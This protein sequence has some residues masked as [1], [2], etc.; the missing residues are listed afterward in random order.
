MKIDKVLGITVGVIVFLFVFLFCYYGHIFHFPMPSRVY[1]KAVPDLFEKPEEVTKLFDNAKLRG[2]MEGATAGLGSR[3]VRSGL[4]YRSVYDANLGRIYWK[5]QNHSNEP[6]WIKSKTLRRL[7]GKLWRMYPGEDL[8]F[9]FSGPPALEIET[10]RL[11]LLYE[12]KILGITFR[13][14]VFGTSMDLLVP[15]EHKF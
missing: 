13:F 12:E 5:F 9:I 14:G 6:I 1:Y 10:A 15:H 2:S 4:S 11:D 7:T 8:Y 3:V